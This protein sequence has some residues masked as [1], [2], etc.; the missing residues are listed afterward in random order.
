MTDDAM[1]ELRRR[2]RTVEARPA[3]LDRIGR[4]ERR[5]RRLEVIAGV[6]VG[7]LAGWIVRTLDPK[8]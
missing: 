7:L 5:V 4:L 2:M 1:D 3:G 6:A 8:S